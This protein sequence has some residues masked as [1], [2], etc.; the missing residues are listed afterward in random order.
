MPYSTEKNKILIFLQKRLIK[1]LMLD[2]KNCK[3][4]SE[5]DLQSC[6]FFHLRRFIDKEKLTKWHI[7]N[8]LSMGERD[9]RKKF[10]DITILYMNEKG[11]KSFPV[12]LLELKESMNFRIKTAEQEMKKLEGMTKLYKD[13]LE[14]TFLIYSCLDKN[15]MRKV[16]QTDKI[17]RGIISQ[18]WKSWIT[19]KTINVLGTKQ[20]SG[21]LAYFDEKIKILR[22]FRGN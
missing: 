2:Q 5:G 17:L 6:V 18:K 8:K 4:V 13:N 15:K 16:S 12:F 14:Q 3:I 9:T 7:L 22:K 20:Y 11:R 21:D 10:P 1:K 19:P